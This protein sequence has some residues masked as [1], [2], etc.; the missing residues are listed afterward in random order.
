MSNSKEEALSSAKESGK[1]VIDTKLST[2]WLFDQELLTRLSRLR[3]S[4]NTNWLFEL[5]V[6]SWIDE[7]I[8]ENEYGK[9]QS[10]RE[11]LW[12]LL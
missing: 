4:V 6:K 7:K 10:E 3:E 9:L 2:R 12:H 1:K 8:L 5:P 11:N